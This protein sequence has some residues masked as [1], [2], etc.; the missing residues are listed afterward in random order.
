[1]W[2]SKPNMQLPKAGQLNISTQ[3]QD[4]SKIEL[5]LIA[6]KQGETS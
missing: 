6:P 3:K 4:P 1:M 5:D 2:V